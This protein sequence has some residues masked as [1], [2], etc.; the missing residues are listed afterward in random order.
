MIRIDGTFVIYK[1]QHLVP[2]AIGLQEK[3]VGSSLDHF[4][5]PH[6][7]GETRSKGIRKDWCTK[8]G[9]SACGDCWQTTGVTGTF[10]LNAASEALA[11]MC[12]K[13]P[14][15]QFRIVKVTISQ[16]TEGWMYGP[17]PKKEAVQA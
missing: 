3:W 2:Q 17:A 7:T 12:Q 5:T 9:F 14:Q 11:W 1:I 6:V 16:T 13:W 15:S 4:G 10:E 8:N